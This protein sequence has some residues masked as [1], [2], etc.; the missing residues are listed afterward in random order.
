MQHPLIARMRSDL[1][2][3][4]FHARRMERVVSRIKPIKPH[5]LMDPRLRLSPEEATI[6]VDAVTIGDHQADSLLAKQLPE[7]VAFLYDL[8][9]EGNRGGDEVLLGIPRNDLVNKI[10]SWTKKQRKKVVAACALYWEG[11]G[12]G[13]TLGDVGLAAP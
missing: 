11:Y 10:A 3:G 7:V 5:K 6:I 12:T 13:V 8:D 1:I 4:V 2:A 9:V